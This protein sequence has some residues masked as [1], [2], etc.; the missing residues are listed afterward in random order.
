[1]A[2][3]PSWS[4]PHLPQWLS[5][6]PSASSNPT[7]SSST[8]SAITPSNPSGISYTT[9]LTPRISDRLVGDKVLLPQGALEALLS[10]ASAAA[11][12]SSVARSRGRGGGES[13]EGW[14]EEGSGAGRGGEG[15][16][17]GGGGLGRS[18]EDGLL[19]HPII[20]RLF[21]PL[22][23]RYTHAVPREFSAEEGVIVL[24]PFLGEVL[25]L[26]LPSPS[27]SPP[28]TLEESAS[29]PATP[30]PSPKIMT[31]FQPLPKAIY[32]RLRP[33]ES[34]YDEA[35]WKSLFERE[36][37]LGH[38]TL[39]AGET[40]TVTSGSGRY[41]FLIDKLLPEES[42]GV[43]VVD[44][45]IEVEMMP[46]SEEQARET[47]QK[48][49]KK[50]GQQAKEW[51]G[52][53]GFGG[54]RKEKGGSVRVGD[55]VQGVVARGEYVDFR[56]EKWDRVRGVA[57]E[58]TVGENGGD[59]EVGGMVDLFIA[60]SRYRGAGGGV[61]GTGGGGA[62]RED[63][64]IWGDLS[65]QSTKQVVIGRGNVELAPLSSELAEGSGEGPAG[66]EYLSI[67]IHGYSPPDAPPTPPEAWGGGEISFCLHI[68]QDE[69]DLSST[70]ATS[71]PTTPGPSADK[72]ICTNCNQPIPLRTYPLH[73]AFCH[74]NN[75][76]CDFSPP[77]SSIFRRNGLPI[78]DVHW[79]CPR[80]GCSAR[81][82]D[83]AR[84]GL[85]KH[86]FIL[87]TPRTCPACGFSARNTPQLAAHRVGDC[88]SKLALCRFCHLLLPQEGAKD[89]GDGDGAG[90][91]GERERERITLYL[92]SGLTHHELA[93]GSRTTECPICHS[94]CRL[95]EF[96]AHKHMH[97]LE[98]LSRPRPVKCGNENCYRVID[99]RGGGNGLGLCAICYGPMYAPGVYDPPPYMQLRRRVERKLLTQGVAGCG[100]GYCRNVWCRT[101]RAKL[102]LAA[103]DG[104]MGGVKREIVG[105]LFEKWDRE[106]GGVGAGGGVRFCVDEVTQRRR[107]V[108]ERVCAEEGWELEWGWV[109][110]KHFLME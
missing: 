86:T 64:F 109:W 70:T 56:L 15:G 11:A 47:V 27:S 96:A 42:E 81:G 34:G 13:W 46:L 26:S 38:S 62:P 91:E 51:V 63:E 60:T 107:E 10:S 28:S 104:G 1:M 33:L 93:C 25:G 74:R 87:H 29:A 43:S 73:T 50:N 32:A 6:A 19:P 110:M 97:E 12:S 92:L 36:L 21:N 3:P 39:T 48:M 2:L 31:S 58:L 9:Q 76:P 71:P 88:P 85:Q 89:H 59:D 103:F 61:D 65:S 79:H 75:I 99:G 78:R 49:L 102:E 67:T 100:R 41:R 52:G 77:C 23:N 57:V 66:V 101:G 24:S 22:N 30:P 98:R 106:G 7:A 69:D 94:R 80:S 72:K 4:T 8:S 45:D 14:R 53:A 37:R 20:F 95:R 90:V 18:G 105:P 16:G 55:V 54:A 5:P 84:G 68:S 108:V 83:A 44:T 17:G 35:D 40:L 82:N